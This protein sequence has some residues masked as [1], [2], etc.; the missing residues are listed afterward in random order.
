MKQTS[1]FLLLILLSFATV[2]AQLKEN[3]KTEFS[4]GLEAG[5]PAGTPGLSNLYSFALGGSVMGTYKIS[6]D[7]RFTLKAGYIHYFIKGGGKGD[8]FIPVLAGFRYYFTPQVYFAGQM[9]IAFS[10]LSNGGSGFCYSPGIGFRL[11]SKV[12]FLV[13]YEA[14]YNSGLNI[15][16]FGARIG[17]NF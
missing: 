3:R 5:L 6:S 12:I 8:G 17:Y 7:F 2:K 10:T 9:G 16:N 1:L 13:R 15:G 4:L 14:T 11:S